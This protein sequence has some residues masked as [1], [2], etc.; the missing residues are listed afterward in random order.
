MASK[1]T[2][3]IVTFNN[4]DVIEKAIESILFHTAGVDLTLYVIDNCSSDNTASIIRKCFDNVVLIE[5]N[6][7]LGF[8]RAHNCVLPF[9]DSD[10]H[11][12]LNP[13]IQLINNAIFDF[14]QFMGNNPDI[15]IAVPKTLNDDL[16]E[17]FTPKL[18]P[19][20]KYMISN[21]LSN[22]FKYFANIRK[23]Y[24][25]ENACVTEPVDVGFCGGCFM[26]IKTSVFKALNGFDESFFLY[27]EDAD[28]TRMAKKYGRAVYNPNICVVHLWERGYTKSLQLFFIQVQSMLKYFWKWR[29]NND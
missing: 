9:L 17:Q 16:T 18:T 6:R 26:F 22:I 11:I 15:A 7:N 12:I 10:Y 1:V 2:V 24:T 27:S 25:M 14:C 3:A 4:A 8:G 28:L 5:N 20:F 23:E 21:R 19:T 29:G 13:D